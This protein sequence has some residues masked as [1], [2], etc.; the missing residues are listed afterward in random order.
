LKSMT[1]RVTSRLTLK[2]KHAL[3]EKSAEKTF[4]ML[5]HRHGR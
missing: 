3:F 5:G 2:R 4:T 1:F